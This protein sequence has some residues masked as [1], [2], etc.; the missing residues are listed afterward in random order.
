M[1]LTFMLPTP[2]SARRESGVDVCCVSRL[3]KLQGKVIA[4][5]T[6]VLPHAR[7]YAKTSISLFNFFY[8]LRE[9]GLLLSLFCRQENRNPKSATLIQV[10]GASNG[11]ARV[12]PQLCP[13][14]GELCQA[15]HKILAMPWLRFLGLAKDFPS[16]RSEKKPTLSPK[17][18][19]SMV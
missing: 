5:L 13:L 3:G 15:S 12:Q 2:D 17:N 4:G 10:H 16:C 9:H 8:D 11:E 7:S 6:V 14:M 18:Y 1:N 19:E